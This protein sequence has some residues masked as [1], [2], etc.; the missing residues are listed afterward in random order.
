MVVTERGV[1]LLKIQYV[2][3]TEELVVSV[4]GTKDIDSRGVL[5][6]VYVKW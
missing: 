2:T 4:L 5:N 6:G 3:E 1:I